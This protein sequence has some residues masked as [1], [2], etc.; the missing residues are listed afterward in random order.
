MDEVT[1]QST[2]WDQQKEKYRLLS[3]LSFD[4]TL[5]GTK[6]LLC[7]TANFNSSQ[8]LAMFSNNCTQAPIPF[9]A[10]I[11]AVCSGFEHKFLP[12]TF[13]PSR[14]PQDGQVIAVIPKYMINTGAFPLRFNPTT[15]LVYIG[16]EDGKIHYIEVSKYTKGA[17]GFG[18]QNIIDETFIRKDIG[19]PKDTEL[20]RSPAVQGDKYCLGVN[21]NVA[22]MT[23][24]ETVEDA[25]VMSDE[26]ALRLGTTGIKTLV[27]NIDKDMVPLNLYGT[28]AEDYKF[29]PDLNEAVREDGIVCAFRK[30]HNSSMISDMTEQ[31]LTKPQ[32]HH[33]EVY[34]AVPGAT[35]IDV[36][37]YRNANRQIKTPA[38]IY[39]QID[40]YIEN[41]MQ[42]HKAIIDLYEK[43]CIQKR[44][45]P[46]PEFVT[47]VERAQRILA[48]NKEKIKGIKTAPKFTYK[49]E[50]IRYIQLVITYTYENKVTKG[51]K[52]TGR[53]GAK[54]VNSVIRPRAD[55]PVD[56]YGNIADLVIA[57]E[58]VINRMNFGQCYEHFINFVGGFVMRKILTMDDYEEKYH[59]VLEFFKDVNSAFAEIVDAV[60]KTPLERKLYIKEQEKLGY[61]VVVVPPGLETLTVD[62]V[63]YMAKKYQ[64]YPTPVEYNLRDIDGKLLRR[65]RTIRPIAIAKK[66]IFILCKIPH[67][68]ACGMAYVNQMGVPIRVK[69]KK[70]KAQHPI[71]LVPI[72]IGEDENRNLVMTV[73]EMAFRILSLYAN[74]PEATAKMTETLLTHP[75]PSKL[76]WV[77]VDLKQLTKSNAMIKVS[78][79]MLATCGIDAENVLMTKEEH[80]QMIQRLSRS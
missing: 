72:R 46:G 52:S 37:I 2:A 66:Y 12:Y 41:N 51:S 31:S 14:M 16:A 48:A 80:D 75:Q 42:F 44:R 79:H 7:P 61:F 24:K 33:D 21:A 45:E 56:D 78:K 15:L 32:Y 71:G 47:L 13:N 50:I 28:S 59:H 19:I 23:M 9:G 8:R 6:S 73:G 22:Y 20:T 77:D 65:V 35:I 10:Q 60:H 36:D 26:L 62:W 70:S 63:D 54:G 68:R 53:E 3:N 38:H 17:E 34:F 29:M 69:H 57:P 55:M 5:L 49:S 64:A 1:T 30:V 18:Y 67:A 27:I 11:P 4:P 76:D 25:F 58:A 74:S 39:A 40:K 43:E